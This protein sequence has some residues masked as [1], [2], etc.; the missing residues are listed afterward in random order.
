MEVA[1]L[2]LKSVKVRRLRDWFRQL[3][4][5]TRIVIYPGVPESWYILRL[6]RTQVLSV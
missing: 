2:Y 5:S 6:R 1:G 3:G 4:D